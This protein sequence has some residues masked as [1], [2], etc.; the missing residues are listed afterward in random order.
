MGLTNMLKATKV[1]IKD[2]DKH[3][4]HDYARTK[5]ITRFLNSLSLV[6]P[7]GERFFMEAI[8]KHEY[9]LDDTLL[10]EVKGFYQQEG[11]HGVFHRDIN[12]LLL[13][14][15]HQTTINIEALDR[16]LSLGSTPEEELLTT[17]S[18][19]IWT[20]LG[21]IILKPIRNIVLKDNSFSTAWKVHA[22]EEFE[23]RKTSHKVYNKIYKTSFLRKTKYF[24]LSGYHLLAQA[25]S[26]SKYISKYKL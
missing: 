12:N 13:A 15:E 4:V 23:H 8:R 3:L 18:L 20:A 11:S 2:E 6:F 1:T 21:A 26:N 5:G 10:K 16:L 7:V 25:K 9:L 19:E 14:K 22:K 24:L 17:C